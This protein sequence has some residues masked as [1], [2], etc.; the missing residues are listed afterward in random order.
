MG[1]AVTKNVTKATA[2]ATAAITDKISAQA[3]QHLIQ[4]NS[5]QFDCPPPCTCTIPSINQTNKAVSTQNLKQVTNITNKSKQDLAQSIS[6][7]AASMISGIPLASISSAVNTANIAINAGQSI[8]EDVSAKCTSSVLQSNAINLNASSPPNQ[9]SY[10][11]QPTGSGCGIHVTGIIDQKNLLNAAQSCTQ[12]TISNNELV[13]DITQ[14]VKQIASAKIKGIDPFAMMAIVMVAIVV[15]VVV[16]AGG[17]MYVAVKTGSYVLGTV[18]SSLPVIMGIG[19]IIAG[20]VIVMIARGRKMPARSWTT[21]NMTG[22][23][24][25]SV[26]ACTT[27]MTTLPCDAAKWG[28]NNDA[29]QTGAAQQCHAKAQGCCISDPSCKAWNWTGYTRD[30]DGTPLGTPTV[31]FYSSVN[32][33][34]MNAVAT[35]ENKTPLQIASLPQVKFSASEGQAPP[36]TPGDDTDV[37]IMTSKTAP[38]IW[39]RAP[40]SDARWLYSNGEKLT[41]IGGIG[42]NAGSL[43][44]AYTASTPTATTPNP[45][46]IFQT[47]LSA[48][49]V[50]ITGGWRTKEE[51]SDDNPFNWRLWVKDTNGNPT[52]LDHGWKSPGYF[53][54]YRDSDS[55]P[56][57]AAGFRGPAPVLSNTPYYTGAALIFLGLIVMSIAS[58][59][60]HQRTKAQVATKQ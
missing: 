50:T 2:R 31:A 58:Y 17:G 40:T 29:C 8:A 24:I 11:V 57:N 42:C 41:S 44:T 52:E 21:L 45:Q 7:S 4:S 23:D 20:I 53:G 34:C 48:T 30:T 10:V 47:E 46:P 37:Y 43:A 33:A 59:V 56:S 38:K 54:K 55:I 36:G 25:Q 18:M 39:I 49:T 19:L 5:F 9:Q 14:K 12:D 51:T 15:G 28:T 6:Q 32:D 22:A 26:G 27:Q 13:Q 1:G 35:T 16:F 60:V 3:H